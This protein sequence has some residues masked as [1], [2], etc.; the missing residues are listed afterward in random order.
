MHPPAT[1]GGTDCVQVRDLIERVA[2]RRIADFLS[3]AGSHDGDL[4]TKQLCV[5]RV[6]AGA[7]E[8]ERG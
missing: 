2:I 6:C 8:E 7:E 1:A 4:E 3:F 5:N